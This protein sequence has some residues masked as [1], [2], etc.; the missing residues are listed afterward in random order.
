MVA[1]V[2]P[3]GVP[4]E[5]VQ[6]TELRSS[7][8]G[9]G[10]AHGELHGIGVDDDFFK[11]DDGGRRGPLEPAQHR[12]DTGD[13]F[14][15]CEGLGDVVVSAE[16]QAQHAI[17]FAG[18]GGQ[19]DDGNGGEAGIAAEP[20]ANIEAVAAGDHDVEQKKGGR[21]ALGVGN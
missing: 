10:S 21:L 15:G 2:N 1:T 20:A 18:A 17:V 3:P 12:F 5:V 14:A 7:G 19:K 13:Q 6:K 9:Q 4:G 11:T 16:F 8:G